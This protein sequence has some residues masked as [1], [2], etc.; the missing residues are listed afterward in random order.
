MLVRDGVFA[1]CLAVAACGAIKPPPSTAQLPPFF[2]GTL[3]DNDIGAINQ[4]AYLL[5]S[6]D[7]TRNN[8]V[9]GLQA[10]IAVEY[11]GGAL[12][13]QPRW[14]EMSPI[15]KMDMLQG[16]EEYRRLL[17][18]KPG[19]PSQLVVNAEIWAMWNLMHGNIA[20]A[21]HVLSGPIFTQPPQQTLAVLINLPYVPAARVAT[22]SAEMQEYHNG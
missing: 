19:T 22:A 21:E 12:N 14:F 17:G 16:R 6:P 15:T 5:G 11:L 9:A 7:R 2:F 10:A 4:A 8:P 3:G 20:A 18:I 13:S 1:A